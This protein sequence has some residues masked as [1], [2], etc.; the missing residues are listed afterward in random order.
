MSS[1][2]WHNHPMS[3]SFTWRRNQGPKSFKSGLRITT[4]EWAERKPW[5]PSHL[6]ST[7][8][9]Y[10]IYRRVRKPWT[11]F[12]LWP[13]LLVDHACVWSPRPDLARGNRSTRAELPASRISLGL[14]REWVGWC[15]CPYRARKWICWARCCGCGDYRIWMD[16][17]YDHRWEL[18]LDHDLDLGH[19]ELEQALLAELYETLSNQETH[20]FHKARVDWLR[21][22]DLNTRFFHAT[23]IRH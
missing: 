11:K 19:K 14:A 23:V 21:G 3:S 4:Y 5:V 9:A 22:G 13:R 12:F 1:T 7:L 6:S 2:S 10:S 8:L 20:L 16:H 18:G 17:A 15:P